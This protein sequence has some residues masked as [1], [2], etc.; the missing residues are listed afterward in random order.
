MKYFW[1]NSPTQLLIL[2]REHMSGQGQQNGIA[3]N[4]WCQAPGVPSLTLPST[5]T[6]G[7]QSKAPLEGRFHLPGTGSPFLGEGSS[8]QKGK[9][10]RI[11][12]PPGSSGTPTELKQARDPG[13]NTFLPKGTQGFGTSPSIPPGG[14]Q[15]L[16]VLP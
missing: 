16:L 1:F 14:T 9:Q 5:C 10:W 4:G 15:L 2:Q 11:P 12:H 7:Q 13:V 8:Q 3:C 6:Q